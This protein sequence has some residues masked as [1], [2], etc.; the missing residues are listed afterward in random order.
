MAYREDLVF[1]TFPRF[2]NLLI[3]DSTFLLN[4]ALQVT[5]PFQSILYQ[6]LLL[7]QRLP[8]FYSFYCR[9]LSTLE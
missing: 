7:F 6:C 4:E 3:N 5:Q 1:T 9:R 8:L 2:F